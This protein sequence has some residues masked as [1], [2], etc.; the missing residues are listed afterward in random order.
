M[1]FRS[2]TLRDI[3]EQYWFTPISVTLKVEDSDTSVSKTVN[4]A[5]LAEEYQNSTDYSYYK[6]DDNNVAIGLVNTNL[7]E[8]NI[9]EY[10]LE[11]EDTDTT[12][13]GKRTRITSVGYYDA[14]NPQNNIFFMATSLKSIEITEG[15]TS[16]GDY[17][18]C[19][20]ANLKSIKL[21]QSLKNINAHAFVSA[22]A[23]EEI[24]LPKNVVLSYNVFGDTN[25]NLKVYF[26]G[27]DIIT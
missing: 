27:E 24:I 8:V 14:A 20:T 1:L 12:L 19:G 9:P 25:T 13:L 17:C 15:V 10:Y 5:A 21:P 18:F 4:V 7:E 22:S 16:I 3:P 26:E 11:V 2:Y 23:L 6:I